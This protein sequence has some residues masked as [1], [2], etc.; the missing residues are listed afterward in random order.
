VAGLDCF[1]R[2]DR[3]MEAELSGINASEAMPLV[4]EHLCAAT[5]S[6][7]SSKPWARSGAASPPR[8]AR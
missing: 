6:E 1:E 8:Y 3:F 7:P 4:H 2:V 5:S